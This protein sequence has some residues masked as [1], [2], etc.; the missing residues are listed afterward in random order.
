MLPAIKPSEGPKPQDF[1]APASPRFP[2]FASLKKDE[3]K[4]ATR[5]LIT[6]TRVIKRAFCMR[7]LV[8]IITGPPTRFV[9]VRAVNKFSLLTLTLPQM[10]YLNIDGFVF[11]IAIYALLSVLINANVKTGHF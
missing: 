1:M 6:E 9:L 4:L 10:V 11:Y 5:K 7:R 8:K 3:E 2:S